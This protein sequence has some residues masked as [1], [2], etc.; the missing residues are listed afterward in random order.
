MERFLGLDY[1]HY[2]EN[3][4]TLS[5]EQC[6][7]M[8]TQ[9]LNEAIRYAEH[10]F[11][12]GTQDLCSCAVAAMLDI[13]YDISPGAF[14]ENELWLSYMKTGTYLMV[15]ESLLNTFWCQ[16]NQKRCSNDRY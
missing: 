10:L 1:D 5:V 12:D 13:I 6:D 15:D 2:A 14:F 11:A 7:S 4:L 16:N 9:K 3:D 8:F